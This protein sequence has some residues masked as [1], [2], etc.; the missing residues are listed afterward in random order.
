[1][2][3]RARWP[4]PPSRV[5]PAA[6]RRP[7]RRA[8]PARSAEDVL[9]AVWDATGLAARLAGAPAPRAARRARPPTGTS[10]PCWPCSTRPRRFADTLPPGAPGPVHRQPGRP[11]DRRRHAGRAGHPRRGGPHPDRAPVQGPGVGRGG[12]RGRPGGDLARPAA[13]RF[14]AG[15]GRA[16]RAGAAGRGQARAPTR[17]RPRWR[18]SCWPRSAGCSTWPSTRADERL[19][20]TAVGG[21]GRPDIRPSRFLTELAG[22]DIEVAAGASAGAPLAVAARARRRPAPRRGRP[23]PP[24]PGP[25]RQAARPQ[26]A[27][28][29]AA[30]VRGAHPREWYALTAAVRRR[31]RS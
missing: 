1:M 14:A 17:P 22:D 20:V 29:A 31:A 15:R 21:D 6:R 16:R 24:A 25:L 12:G 27:R 5:G 4:G 9:W 3:P 2:V 8:R 7:G 13:A 19:V 28:L 26:L 10:T 18:P 23:L 30:G 11:G